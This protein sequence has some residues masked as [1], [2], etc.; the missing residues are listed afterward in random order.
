MPLSLGESM[1]LTQEDGL[2]DDQKSSSDVSDSQRSSM[3]GGATALPRRWDGW[4]G[5]QEGHAEMAGET[6]RPL[7]TT[8]VGI[9]RRWGRMRGLGLDELNAER[10]WRMLTWIFRGMFGGGI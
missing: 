7:N 9:G 6:F 10:M 2:H 5:G 1:P 8:T 3:R 4:V